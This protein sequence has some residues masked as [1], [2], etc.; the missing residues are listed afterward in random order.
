VLQRAI[1]KGILVLWL[2]RCYGNQ[3]GFH[4]ALLEGIKTQLDVERG[5]TSFQ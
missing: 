2:L 4:C 1:G 5:A 3:R